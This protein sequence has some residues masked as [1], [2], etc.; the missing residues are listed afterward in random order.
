MILNFCVLIN[1]IID[2]EKVKLTYKFAFFLHFYK[3]IISLSIALQQKATCILKSLSDTYKI[4]ELSNVCNTYI[5]FYLRVYYH[6][7]IHSN[8]VQY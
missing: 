3:E 1:K 7:N 2:G 8:E 6:L 5:R 4:E